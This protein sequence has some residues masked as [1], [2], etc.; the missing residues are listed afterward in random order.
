MYII[1]FKAISHFSAI[2]YLLWIILYVY[3][4]NLSLF[5]F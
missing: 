5:K 3:A 4:I 1:A 2:N